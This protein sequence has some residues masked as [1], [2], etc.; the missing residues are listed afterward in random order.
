MAQESMQVMLY[1][2]TCNKMEPK[3]TITT[4]WGSVL[5][6]WEPLVPPLGFQTHRYQSL[7]SLGFGS[8]P[9]MKDWRSKF[10][11]KLRSR[12]SLRGRFGRCWV[13][14]G[15]SW[16]MLEL[17]CDI[18]GNKMAT[19]SLK[20]SQD[21]AQEPQDEPR[22]RPRGCQIEPRWHPGLEIRSFYNN[23]GIIF[24]AF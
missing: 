20:M 19:K 4:G 16:L 2:L 13:E 6:V 14:F 11:E 9:A 7:K 8:S 18:F 15:L 3:I 5:P 17:C 10:G 23:F 24:D 22:W 12:G 21:G 1:R